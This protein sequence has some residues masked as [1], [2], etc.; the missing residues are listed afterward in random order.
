MPAH[1]KGSK[2]SKAAQEQRS[3]LRYHQYNIKREKGGKRRGKVTPNQDQ[4]YLFYVFPVPGACT[5]K[6]L[7]VPRPM[8]GV[9]ESR[10]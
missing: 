10:S 6:T 1:P 9:H 3:L 4:V 5:G 7:S 8:R 2:A